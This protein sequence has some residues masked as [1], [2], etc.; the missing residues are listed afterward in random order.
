MPPTVPQLG[1]GTRQNVSRD[2]VEE[3]SRRT[4]KLVGGPVEER[5]HRV[6]LS[7]DRLRQFDLK[8]PGAGSGSCVYRLYGSAGR[9][10]GRASLLDVEAC[11]QDVGA[12]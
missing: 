11:R 2:F 5:R 10:V 8:P 1:E 6:A 3:R 12:R 7:S 9:L 4:R